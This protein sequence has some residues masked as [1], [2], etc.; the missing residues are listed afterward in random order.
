M[1]STLE[2][3]SVPVTRRSPAVPAF[4]VGL[5]A[6]VI[7]IGRLWLFDRSAPAEV[8][9]AEDGLFP[10]CI[11]KADFF[12]CL[13][14]PFAG[15]LLFLPRVL[16]W[17]VATLP[18]EHWALA[19]NAIAAA[20]A[21]VTAALAFAIVRRAGFGWF[22]SIAVG[23][24]PV[25]APMAGL[26]AINAIGSSYMLLLFLATLLIV[27][28]PTGRRGHRPWAYTTAGSVLLVVTALT[29]PSAVVL[30]PILLVMVARA[31]W[32][33]RVGAIWALTLVVGLVA[34]AATAL[35][36]DAPRQVTFG[37]ATLQSWADS[38]PV[39]LLTYWPG[40]SIGDYAFFNNF[41][42]TPLAATGWLIAGVMV[43]VG[44]WFIVRD[45]GSRLAIGLLLLGGLAFGLIPSAI[46]F[47]N[48]RYFVVP[49]LLWGTA[50]LLGLD[51][52][53]RRSRP[54]VVGLVTLL[55]LIIWWPA[56][57]A[58]AFRATPAPPWSAEVDRIEAKCIS[59]PAFVD[60][61]LF[62]PFW[63]PNWGDGLIEPTHPNLPCTTVW[64]W[65][66]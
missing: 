30:L 2:S 29:I 57:A 36:A 9:W 44:L 47:A 50:A 14:D 8:L 32:T 10:L 56:M 49:L 3:T 16:A 61:P 34:Q 24:L 28:P 63:P 7:S 22:T 23:L 18:W 35:T 43:V 15:Y 1:T 40:L 54:V 27:L 21:G 38:I 46:G 6:A 62:T 52:I 5:V 55:V 41:S 4:M 17:P 26:E 66:D 11:R 37:S 51:P 33:W 64:R 48:N 31:R 45:S 13:T 53:V 58:S 25:L 59:D 39:S 20:L 65:L 42:L 60:R 19:A 12:T